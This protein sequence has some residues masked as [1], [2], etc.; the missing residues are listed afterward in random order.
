MPINE[1]PKIIFT[2]YLYVKDEVMLTLVTSILEKRESS[3]FWAYEL[4]YSGFENELFNLLWKI[5]FDF[6]YTLNPSFYDYFI[7]KQK[8]WTKMRSSQERDKIINMIVS[9]LLIRPHNLDVFLL[10][11]ISQNFVVELDTTIFNECQ[12]FE[13]I[14]LSKF[15]HW[16]SSKNYQ[17]ISEFVL[18]KCS[19]NQLDEFLE[20]AVSYFQDKNNKNLTKDYNVKEK[21]NKRKNVDKN[22]ET[23]EKRHII[24]AHIIMQFTCIENVKMGKKLYVI[25]EENEMKQF[26][27]I[28]SDYDS[29]FYPYKILPKACLYSIDE[30]NYLTLF[31]LKRESFDLNDAYFNHWEYYAS[32]SPVW[33]DRIKKYNG[34]TN[35]ESKK[36]DFPDDE[37]FD[38]FYDAFNYETDEQKKETSNKSIQTLTNKRKWFQVYEQHKKNGIFKPAIEFLEELDKVEY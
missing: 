13:F 34:V 11:Q 3:M 33:R 37:C 5:Y 26:E 31:K 19:E 18:N 38:E 16:F 20:Y 7:K 22:E 9:D 17:N 29:S 24:L 14:H 21:I 32:F 36:I 6:Y 28:Y 12:K 23:C 15:D 1:S 4:Y 35:H 25:V 27:T 30:E 10:R 2:R 8:E